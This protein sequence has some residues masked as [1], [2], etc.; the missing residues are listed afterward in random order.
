MS[1]WIATDAMPVVG[2]VMN[3]I[4]FMRCIGRHVS[5][6]IPLSIHLSVCHPVQAKYCIKGSAIH[7]NP[8]Q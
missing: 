7:W 8:Q 5:L 2:W 6:A 3:V 1:E 4:T